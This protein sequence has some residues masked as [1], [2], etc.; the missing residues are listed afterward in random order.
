MKAFLVPLVAEST[1][2]ATLGPLLTV[3]REPIR[4]QLNLAQGRRK[5]QS[6][7]FQPHANSNMVFLLE[8][9]LLL[10]VLL[11]VS[12]HVASAASLDCSGVPSLS[13]NYNINNNDD[14]YRYRVQDNPISIQGA[15]SCQ[16]ATENTRGSYTAQ[17][18]PC[19][20][21]FHKSDQDDWSPFATSSMCTDDNTVLSAPVMEYVDQW[22]DEC[23]GNFARC[24]SVEKDQDI[25]R[26]FACQHD[27]TFPEGTTHLRVNCT[28]NTEVVQMIATAN[29]DGRYEDPYMKEE[30]RT[31]H[32]MEVVAIVISLIFVLGC[33]G[34]VYCAYRFIVLP[35]REST[36]S[37]AMR[38][39][40]AALVPDVTENGDEEEIT[41]QIT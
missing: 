14:E 18:R 40:S 21:T 22:P 33:C 9:C 11:S 25:F 26:V 30:Q 29:A 28:A 34:C 5:R 13:N 37:T 4:Y 19:A 38:E 23:V 7:P 31:L 17:V 1:I 39:Q 32:E 12:R 27:W 16:S 36:D 10:T 2:K 24:Y 8:R 20:F 6:T 35:Y 15:P 41:A 3:E